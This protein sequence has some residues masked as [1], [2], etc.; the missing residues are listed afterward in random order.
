MTL[1][2]LW[3]KKEEILLVPWQKTLQQQKCQKGKVTT[4]TTP[5]KVRLHDC[6]WSWPFIHQQGAL[7]I[8]RKHT[9]IWHF[10]RFKIV[11]CTNE[12]GINVPQSALFLFYTNYGRFMFWRK[13]KL[14]FKWQWDM[15][16]IVWPKYCWN[17]VLITLVP[18]RW[19]K[20]QHIH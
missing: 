19:V 3:E 9:P 17:M 11:I 12:Y 15:D 13:E 16:I 1:F 4:Q 5:Q 2:D 18:N 10:S 8:C 6:T 20:S 14:L 7:N